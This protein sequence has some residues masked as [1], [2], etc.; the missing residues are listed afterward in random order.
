MKVIPIFAECGIGGFESPAQEYKELELSLDQ[1]LI[2]RPSSTFLGQAKGES[3]VAEGIFDGDI[4][5]V[6]RGTTAGHMDVI[7]ANYNGQFVCKKLD[8]KGRRLL[9]CS[10]QDDIEISEADTFAIEGVV[11]S[12][13]RAHRAMNLMGYL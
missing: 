4:L 1:L 13:I 8:K 10:E 6:D 2:P 5:I 7:V 9:S 3:M 12:S 11:I